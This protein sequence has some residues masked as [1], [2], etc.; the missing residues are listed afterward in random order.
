M[1]MILLFLF[2]NIS[3]AIGAP[4]KKITLVYEIKPN[5]PFYLGKKMIDWNRPGITLEVI[6]LLERK[7]NIEVD[8]E[9]LPW[10]IGLEKVKNNEVDG[11]FHASFKEQR[12]KVGVYPMRNGQPDTNRRLMTQSYFLYK[13][14]NS[15]LQWD[16]NTFTNLVGTI[17]VINDYAVVGDLKDMNIEVEEVSTQLVNLRRLVQ[18]RVAGIAGLELMN[19]FHI[20]ARPEE[21]KEI[22]K[23]YPPIA[24]KPYYLMLSHELV[25]ENP[26]LAE[27]IWDAIQDIRVSEEYFQ[28]AKKYF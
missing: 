25:G 21:F 8:F 22:V 6:K 27:A 26:D 24:Q 2:L 10:A 13:R 16:G 17:G 23:V 20:N 11:I 9:R 12:L 28:I 5:P 1:K 7:L 19:D 14:K 15:P 3:V 18:G 4:L